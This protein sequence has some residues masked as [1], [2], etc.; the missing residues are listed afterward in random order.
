[1]HCMWSRYAL[2]ALGR[3]QSTL[4]GGGWRRGRERGSIF[5]LSM[6][7]LAVLLLLG[8]ISVQLAVQSLDR[9]AKE[10]DSA[11]AFNLAE[12]AADCAEAWLRAQSAPPLDYGPID[13]LGGEQTLGTGTYRAII[14]PDAGNPGAWLKSYTIVGTGASA[15]GGASRRVILKVQEQSFALYSY[16][17]DQERSSVTNGTIW[18]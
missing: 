14:Y 8:A 15:R 4:F 18:F 3:C 9:A 5:I 11:V 12:S 10:R 13:P 17:T 6:V 7:A 2:D 16:F 1:M